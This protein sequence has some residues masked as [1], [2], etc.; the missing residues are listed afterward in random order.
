MLKLKEVQK[1]TGLSRSSIYSYID[2][3]LFPTQ[4]KLG[5]RSVAWVDQEITDWVES[6]ISVRDAANSS[7]Y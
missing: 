1:I 4:V 7:T 5:E 3:G 2:K 6:R